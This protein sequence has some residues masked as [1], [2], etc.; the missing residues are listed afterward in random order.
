MQRGQLRTSCAQRL[1]RCLA[2]QFARRISRGKC[3]QKQQ[4]YTRSRN[5]WMDLSTRIYANSG[6][7]EHRIRMPTNLHILS[8][9]RKHNSTNYDDCADTMHEMQQVGTKSGIRPQGR[10]ASSKQQTYSSRMIR[11]PR[12][13]NKGQQTKTCTRDCMRAHRVRRHAVNVSS[14]TTP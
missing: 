12:T 10:L 2:L 7:L 3:T 5:G 9:G 8:P 11:L 6:A 1:C 13:K 4:T 14:V